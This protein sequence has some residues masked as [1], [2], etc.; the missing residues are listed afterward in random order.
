VIIQVLKQQSPKGKDGARLRRARLSHAQQLSSNVGCP[1]RALASLNVSRGG[2]QEACV[3]LRQIVQI[4]HT[5]GVKEQ[6]TN[7]YNFSDIYLKNFANAY[8]SRPNF[9]MRNKN[10]PWGSIW[11]F[12]YGKDTRT[13]ALLRRPLLYLIYHFLMLNPFLKK[14]RY[15]LNFH[16]RSN[17]YCYNP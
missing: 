17:G 6:H 14:V 13:G 16:C 15:A 10:P 11:I 7:N 1:S 4:K 3:L 5:A 8:V 12:L 2:G 9:V